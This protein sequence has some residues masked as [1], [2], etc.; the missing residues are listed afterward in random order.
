M[1]KRSIKPYR[2]FLMPLSNGGK[3]LRGYFAFTR[4]YLKILLWVFCAG[5][6]ALALADYLYPHLHLYRFF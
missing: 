2:P 1:R 4:V 5:L 6:F 3:F